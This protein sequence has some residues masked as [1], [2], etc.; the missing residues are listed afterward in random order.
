MS[1]INIFTRSV[2]FDFLIDE[3]LDNEIIKELK[4]QENLNKKIKHSNVG[5][6]HSESINNKFICDKILHKSFKLITDNYKLKNRTNFNLAN[7]WINKN[8]KYHFNTPHVH[9]A[10]SFSGV[11]YLNVPEKNGEL[12]FLENDMYIMNDL[13]AFIDSNEFS[14]Y[15]EVTP[16]KN[17]FL[18]FPSSFSHM[19]NPHYEDL[20]RISVSFNIRLNDGQENI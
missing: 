14:S 8:N 5:G 3:K 16:K 7:L 10:S 17:M 6:F 11:Y 2:L 12:V 9:S 4:I 19:V 15:H 20:N 18:I 1:K 13:N